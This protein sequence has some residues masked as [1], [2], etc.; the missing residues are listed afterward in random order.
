MM[1]MIFFLICGYIKDYNYVFD[2]RYLLSKICF[3]K[4]EIKWILS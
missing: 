3:I 2:V 1:N 4:S